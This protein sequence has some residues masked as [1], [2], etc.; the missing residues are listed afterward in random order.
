MLEYLQHL[1]FPVLDVRG[2][3]FVVERPDEYGGD[4]TYESYDE[5]ERTSSA[6]NSTPPT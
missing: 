6:A 3:S 1:V 2:D 5:V 4:L